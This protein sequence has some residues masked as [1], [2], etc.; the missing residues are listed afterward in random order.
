[1]YIRVE[2]RPVNITW[3]QVYAPTTGVDEKD[4]EEFYRNLQAVLNEIPR[5]DVA[6]LMGSWNAK[7]G[8]GEESEMAGNYGLGNRNEAG[9]H[10]LEFCEENASLWQTPFSNS[11]NRDCIC[12]HHRMGNTRIK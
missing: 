12:G 10:L 11:Q 5:K 2:A 3:V 1:M 6:I 9:E 4:I 8:K 7:I